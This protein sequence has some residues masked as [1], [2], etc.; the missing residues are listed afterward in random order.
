MP[1]SATYMKMHVLISCCIAD[2]Q[3]GNGRVGRLILFK[4]CL[5]NNIAPFI[6]E[7]EDKYKASLDYYR[8]PYEK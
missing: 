5:R 4:E 7:G 6:I 3:D 2:N 1:L 8:I